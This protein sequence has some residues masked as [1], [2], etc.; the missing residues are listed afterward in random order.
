MKI[1][2]MMIMMIKKKKLFKKMTMLSL[3]ITDVQHT[4]I[5]IHNSFL[6]YCMLISLLSNC[7]I[8]CFLEGAAFAVFVSPIIF[9]H[10]VGMYLS[11]FMTRFEVFIHKTHERY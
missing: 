1:L 9:R 6:V 7:P 4:R 2:M 10:P 8:V 11:L 3:S 5:A